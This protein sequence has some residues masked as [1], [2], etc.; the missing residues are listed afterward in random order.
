MGSISA[1]KALQVCGN[2]EKILA[3]EMLCAAQAVDFQRPLSS[4]PVLEAVH[5]AI[6]QQI[7]FATEDRIFAKDIGAALGILQR[8]DLLAATAPYEVSDAFIHAALLD[9]F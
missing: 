6:R 3:V 1:R 5:A 9:K 2:V 4:S 7:P 8:G